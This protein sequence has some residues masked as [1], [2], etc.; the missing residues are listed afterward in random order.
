MLSFVFIYPPSADPTTAPLTLARI[1]GAV[2]HCLHGKM[3]AV[4]LDENRRFVKYVIDV[5]LS[6]EL[7]R[8][9]KDALEAPLPREFKAH[10]L[11]VL[12]TI[13]ELPKNLLKAL[14]ILKV[15]DLFLNINKYVFAYQAIAKTFELYSLPYYPALIGYA[16]ARLAF[17]IR[18]SDEIANALSSAMFNP[19][20]NYFQERVEQI[21]QADV[22]GI[23]VVYSSQ[24]FPAL[25]LAKLIKKTNREALVLFG[26]PCASS[27][28]TVL[29]GKFGD[30]VDMVV[31]GDAESLLG[32]LASVRGSF[33]EK[34]KLVEGIISFKRAPKNT[35]FASPTSPVD[36]SWASIDEYFLP[37]PVF[38]L[39]I[40]RGCYYG[41]CAFC[42]YGSKERKYSKMRAS[43][44]L[45]KIKE[46][47]KRFGVSRF[48]FT[49]DVVDPSLLEDLSEQLISTKIDI[50]YCLDARLEEKFADPAFAN[51]L[52]EGGCRAISFGMESA[53]Q[54]T[55]DIMNKAT[56][57]MI[58]SSILQNLYEH[59]IHVQVHLI[60]G[61]PGE[62]INGIA[63]TIRFLQ[64][65]EE[66]I[67]TA[68]TSSFALLKGS[69]VE[70]D[71][72]KYG[73]ASISSPGDMA[74]DYEYHVKLDKQYPSYES[75]KTM[76]FELFPAVGRLTGSTTDYLIYASRYT[77][78]QMKHM[79]RS[80]VG[81]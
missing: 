61:F 42:A 15:P 28:R 57:S 55:L 35:W 68:G 62:S 48:F 29:E 66:K 79:L 21:G 16:T 17:D 3:R 43:E 33:R 69:M 6:G 22:F 27:L 78:R 71:P 1:K 64:E 77:P 72:A 60:H 4:F 23:S 13:D 40:T 73:I 44:I 63:Q 18:R 26:G 46:L 34:R 52:F 70:Q 10:L 56:N 31:P 8:W 37:E 41:K 51:K 7:E 47:K 59:Q 45:G 12:K 5:V 11:D 25:T 76:V 54:Q 49:V 53:C 36:Y 65:N 30:F 80:A 75:F 14:A 58:F 39:D 38:C 9:G 67:T 24:L 20:L 81:A 50:T 74:L 19:Y 32:H 2:E